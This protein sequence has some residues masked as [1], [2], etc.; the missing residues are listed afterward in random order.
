MVPVYSVVNRWKRSG[1]LLALACLCLAIWKDSTP[2]S[3]KMQ[4]RYTQKRN[5][6]YCP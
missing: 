1:W 2:I 3:R 6:F 4:G 5:E